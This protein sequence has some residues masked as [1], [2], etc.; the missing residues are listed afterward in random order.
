MR[1]A[2]LT[3]SFLLMSMVVAI[4]CRQDKPERQ[5]SSDYFV[6]VVVDGLRFSEGWGDSTH[7]YIPRMSNEM[8][9]EGTVF[10]NF[11]MN[12]PTYTNAG[13]TAVLTGVYQEIDNFGEEIPD[14]PNYLQYW[15]SVTGANPEDAWV[16]ASKHKIEALADCENGEW[17][18]KY[19]PRIDCG[20]DGLGTGH[21]TDSVTMSRLFDT[22]NT[23]HP[24]HVL[25]N[26]REPDYSGHTGVW[27]DYLTG[28]EASD[29]YCYQ[30]WNYLQTD[31]IYSG[32]T[33]L[34]ITN[35]HGRHLD[36]VES[37]FISHG[38]SCVGCRHIFAYAYGPDI[39]KGKI[40]DTEY[41]LIDIPA[42][43][44]YMQGFQMPTGKGKVM[45]QMFR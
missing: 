26:L 34:I 33:T 22:L 45:Y 20:N 9:K 31:Y 4:G 40:I 13:H 17:A 32:N 28:I 10:S 5:F 24:H 27:E 35:D 6:V 15:R 30:I 41:E 25:I 11:R 29:E 36:G 12:G 7:Q 3:T 1:R 42:T 16:I 8:A 14:N 39:A 44:S 38:D 19:L 18:G 43:I 21:R 23:Y 37:G 2:F